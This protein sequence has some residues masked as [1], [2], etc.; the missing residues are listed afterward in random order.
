[1]FKTSLMIKKLELLTV[2]FVLVFLSFSA[3]AQDG[4]VASIDSV[5]TA[6]VTI[7]RKPIEIPVFQKIDLDTIALGEHDTLISDSYTAM[8]QRYVYDALH[9]FNARRMDHFGGYLNVKINE[10]L[11]SV[12]RKGFSSDVKK[13]YIQI[14]PSTL[15][16]YW[17]A[18]VGPSEDGRCCIAVDSRGSAGGGLPAVLK[19]CPRMHGLH[20]GMQPEMLLNFNDNVIQ[21]FDWKGNK[22]DTAYGF[23]NIQQHFYKYYNPQI[24]STISLADY[25][26]QENQSLVPSA[27][28]AAAP[29]AA[30]VAVTV[31]KK[32]AP[33]VSYS[34]Y[35]VKSGDTL[36]EIAEKYHTSVAKIKKA[37]GMRSDMIQIGQTLKIPR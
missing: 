28:P 36:S 6:P 18:V 26:K 25:V 22:L 11:A 9:S 33:A 4:V 37:N 10:G 1:M 32:T 8:G 13:L 23:V 5:P 30:P 2:I 7:Q 15:T 29:V 12:R 21:C 19:Q 16:V 27:I 34:R 20:D 17:T 14:D 31:A 35:K 24:G 3:K